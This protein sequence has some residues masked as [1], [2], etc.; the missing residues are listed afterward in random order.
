M[1]IKE[2]VENV[3]KNLVEQTINKRIKWIYSKN[4][5]EIELNNFCFTFYISWKLTFNGWVS[6]IGFLS[7]RDKTNKEI[8]FSFFKTDYSDLISKLDSFFRE[9]FYNQ[10]KPSETEYI[11]RFNNLSKNL[12]LEEYRNSKIEKIFKN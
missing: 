1:N 4:K 2:S 8:N 10:N 5:A 11:D 6:D 7:L 3:L 12:S 9:E